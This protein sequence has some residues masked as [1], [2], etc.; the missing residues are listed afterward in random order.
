M[1]CEVWLVEPHVKGGEV[2]YFCLSCKDKEDVASTLG[3]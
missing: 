2:N 3:A 1:I